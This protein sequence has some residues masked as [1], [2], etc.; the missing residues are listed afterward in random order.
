[1]EVL[2]SPAAHF[3]ASLYPAFVSMLQDADEE[4]RSNAVFAIGILMMQGQEQ[5]LSYP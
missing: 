4:V 2:G 1:M 3:V 5:A